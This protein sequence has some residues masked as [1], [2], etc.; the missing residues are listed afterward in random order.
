MLALFPLVRCVGNAVLK[1]GLRGLAGLLPFGAVAS[2]VACDALQEYRREGREGEL[3][4][5]LEAL[6][7]AS[8]TEARE[9]AERVA[10]ELASGRPEQIRLT[11]VDY[12]AQMPAT[13]RQS[14]RRTA[15]PGGTTIPP[16]LSVT[17]PED[18][19]RCLPDRLPRFRSGGHVDGLGDWELEECLG[20]GGF[21]EVWRASNPHLLETAAVKFCLDPATAQA[22]RNEA[23][24]LRRVLLE[25][26]HPG[27]VRLLDTSLRGETSWL[28]YEYV[29]GGDLAGV[30]RELAAG[31]EPP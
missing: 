9:A 22:L 27:I 12:L 8:A 11:L 13:V 16:A 23:A 7:R 18:L 24:L 5:D 21:G 25:G 26:G 20:V 6:A 29:Q 28:R 19:L 30:I 14:F 2:D 4:E 15:D 31:G 17:R 10:Q 3:R 1:H